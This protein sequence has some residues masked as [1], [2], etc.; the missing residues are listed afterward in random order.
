[1]RLGGCGDFGD[2]QGLVVGLVPGDEAFDRFLTVTGS[3]F[4]GVAVGD[5]LLLGKVGEVD[6]VGLVFVRPL[7]DHAVL[8]FHGLLSSCKSSSFWRTLATWRS[9]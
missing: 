9:R 4:V 1:V 6:E 8:G 3:F 5:E 2:G 7:D